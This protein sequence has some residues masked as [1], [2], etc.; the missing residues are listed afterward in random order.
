MALPIQDPQACDE[1]QDVLLFISRQTAE[2]HAETPC[3]ALLTTPIV[4]ESNSRRHTSPSIRQEYGLEYGSAPYSAV[5][6]PLSGRRNY[7]TASDVT[8]GDNLLSLLR[9]QQ[10]SFWDLRGDAQGQSLTCH[11]CL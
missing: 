4:T 5:D 10:V 1:L 9:R 8:L 3:A 7:D 11:P 6:E 2:R